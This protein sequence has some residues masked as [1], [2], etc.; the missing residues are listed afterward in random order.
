MKLRATRAEALPTR[1]YLGTI[2]GPAAPRP[3]SAK[4]SCGPL[5]RGGL[6]PAGRA[7]REAAREDSRE[8]ARGGAINTH[9]H[10]VLPREVNLV[11]LPAAWWRLI[12]S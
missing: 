7:E 12:A 6:R 9:R 5:C 2:V 3:R 11:V 10:V 1:L 4:L 8:G